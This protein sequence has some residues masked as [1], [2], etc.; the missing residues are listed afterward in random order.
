VVQFLTRQDHVEGHFSF[1]LTPTLEDPVRF[2]LLQQPFPEPEYAQWWPVKRQS[3]VLDH[4][5]V[6]PAADVVCYQWLVPLRCHLRRG[7][8]EPLTL[9]AVEV[10]P[11]KRMV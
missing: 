1:S 4:L 3:H 6:P 8:F 5:A 11:K 10:Q 2:Q 9:A 7:E